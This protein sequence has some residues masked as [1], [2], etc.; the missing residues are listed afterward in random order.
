M[1]MDVAHHR[2]FKPPQ[3]NDN[4]PEVCRQFLKLKF[5]NKGIDAVSLSIILRHKK[6]QSCIPEYFKSKSTP[7]I[8]YKYTPTIAS[9]LFN[10]KTISQ[11]LDIEHLL[12]NP[13]TFSCSTS[14]FNYQPAG[15]AITGDVNIVKN[16]ELKSLI[17]KGPKFREPR[18]FKWQQNFLSIM[19]SV[20]DYARQWAKS[21]KELDSLSEWVKSIRSILKSRIKH[22]RSKMRTNYPSAFNKPEVIRELN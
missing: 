14:R 7:C 9:K 19:E 8:S 12:L 10:Y 21:E 6:V 3:I 1:I 18:S 13:P 20:E 22:A 17:L 11:C 2:L 4:S 15:H 5:S 16:E